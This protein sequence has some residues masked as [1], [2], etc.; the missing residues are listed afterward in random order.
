[1][2]KKQKIFIEKAIILNE[3]ELYKKKFQVLH[4]INSGKNYTGFWGKN[5]YRNI[6]IIGEDR[7]GILYNITH[8]GQVDV[9]TFLDEIKNLK[10]DISSKTDSLRLWNYYEFKIYNY[11]SSLMFTNVK[12]E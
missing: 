7:E 9:I 10:M 4:I 12:G 2:N 6:I 5:G 3:D 1:M 8:Y 11:G